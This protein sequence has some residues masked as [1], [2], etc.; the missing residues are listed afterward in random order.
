MSTAR[1]PQKARRVCALF[2]ASLAL[3]ILVPVMV[4]FLLTS[5]TLFVFYTNRIEQQGLTN[6][7]TELETFTSS[8]AAE[9]SEPLW[10]FQ[11]DLINRLMRSYRDNRNLHSISLY[12]PE[13]ELIAQAKGRNAN[14]HP[15]ELVSERLITRE[16]GGEILDLGRLVVQYHDIH[17]HSQLNERRE[18]DTTFIIILII[19]IGFTA[20][21]LIH[22]MVGRPLERLK[23][24]LR[25]NM[26]SEKRIPLVWDSNDELGQ[27]VDDYNALLEEV[28]SQT[29]KLVKA[30]RVMQVEIAQRRVAEQELAK[31]HETLENEVTVR[32][33]ELE[34]ANAELKELD[35]QRAAFLSLASHELRTPLAAILGFSKLIKKSFVRLFASRANEL[36]LEDKADQMLVNMKII[37]KEGTR[38]TRLIDDLL[39]LNKIEAGQMEWR[40]EYLDM[41]AEI[42]QSARTMRTALEETP[43]VEL[44]VTITEELPKVFMDPDRVQQ[45]LI[46]LLSNAVKHT[47][48]GT[49]DIAAGVEDGRMRVVVSDTGTG[50]PETDHRYIFHKFYQS[51]Q[52]DTVMHTGTG[53]G[54]PICK[55]IVEH[56]GGTI[57]VESEEGRGSR[58]IV[59]LPTY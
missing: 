29:D 19:V 41:A 49:I 31:I 40:N 23:M 22:S 14:D 10:N 18:S 58:F 20:W 35:M 13:G 15:T 45:V 51:G 12:G 1:L 57:A 8:K 47:E 9:L 6:L 59:H 43:D 28:E 36:G 25:Q 5:I 33:M 7:R 30:N 11:D 46:N 50:I 16:V 44:T 32:T 4:V 17:L 54:L 37:E 2:T 26:A 48:K 53:L 21:F 34:Q 38:L 55:S 39:D 56:Y 52:R 27:V 3:K 42:D 24:S